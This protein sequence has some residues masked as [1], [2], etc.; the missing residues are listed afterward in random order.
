MLALA[1]LP[2]TA[3]A[4]DGEGAYVPGQAVVGLAGGG[5][6]IAE[7][8][9]GRS[10]AEG[11]AALE[12]RPGVRFAAPNWIARAAATPLDHGTSPLPGGWAID[13]WSFG[14]RPGGIRV[15]GAWDRL[16]E[17]GR[18]GGAGVTVAIV[19]SGLAY[20][21]APGYSPSPDFDSTQFVPGID[22]VDDDSQPLDGNG[23]GTHVAGTIAEQVTIGQPS[24]L[25]DYETG[26]AYGVRLM[27]V[28]VLDDDGV[29]STDDVAAGILWAARKGADIINLSL[30]FDPAV[31]DCGQ[32][33]TVCE[34]I[35]K[36]DDYGALVV[37]SAGNALTTSG[38][39]RALFPA[40]APKAF[41]VGATTEDGCL[42]AYSYYGKRTDLLAPGGGLPRPAASRPVCA[43]DTIPILQLTYACFPMSCEGGRQRFA[44]RPDVGTSMSAAHASAVA[45]LVIASGVAGP[46]PDP[47][48]LELRLECTARP[49]LPERFYGAGLLDA[50]RAV[51][52]DRHCDA[53]G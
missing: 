30:N 51:D 17:L 36:A 32:V 19:D 22:L 5:S 45:A 8:P 4:G 1:A 13:Q 53:P 24:P 7:L 23:H 25:P 48:R 21:S 28:R 2:A 34:A 50:T 47:E 44:I 37:G 16:A 39:N 6:T 10:V 52:P 3:A 33:P 42:A 18:P 29:G 46:D 26:I 35:R 40:A 11:I 9:P 27:P 15:A 14:A 43:D 41:A 12:R 49:A 31:S 38:R 20:E